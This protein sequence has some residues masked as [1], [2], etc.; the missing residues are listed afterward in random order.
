MSKNGKLALGVLSIV[1]L[2]AMMIWM[3]YLFNKM[4]VFGIFEG[5]RPALTMP[6]DEFRSLFIQMA[7]FNISYIVLV[8][9]QIFGHLFYLLRK[10][11]VRTDWKVVWALLLVFFNALA[12]PLSWLFNIWREPPLDTRRELSETL[13]VMS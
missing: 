12:L 6:K 13:D 2:V 3:P 9:G 11:N 4:G 10:P 8:F 7:L 1:P 5:D